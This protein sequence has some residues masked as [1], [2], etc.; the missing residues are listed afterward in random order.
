MTP[1]FR[2]YRTKWIIIVAIIIALGCVGYWKMNKDAEDARRLEQL[3]SY[4]Q[5]RLNRKAE[6]WRRGDFSDHSYEDRDL[7][8]KIDDLSQ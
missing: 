1:Y 8:R 3:Q 6:R 4:L 5:M 2:D 7:D